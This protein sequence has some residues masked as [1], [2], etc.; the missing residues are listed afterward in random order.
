M[1]TAENRA[2]LI[3]A[4]IKQQKEDAAVLREVCQTLLP[5]ATIED[6]QLYVWLQQCDDVEI[7]VNAIEATSRWMNR[8]LQ[9]IEEHQNAGY[10]IPEGL[11]KTNVDIIKYLSGTIKG[12][13]NASGRGFEAR[14]Q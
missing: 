6:R 3:L 7:I 14:A 10:E 11:Q 2:A 4:R 9:S 13:K 5:Y 12:M 1:A 8:N